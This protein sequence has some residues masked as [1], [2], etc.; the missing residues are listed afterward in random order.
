MQDLIFVSAQPDIPYFHWQTQVYCHNFIEKGIDPKNIHV[1]F[2]MIN[3]E[4]PTE[5]SLKLKNIGVNV[6]H[7]LD[8]RKDKFYIPSLRPM[9]LAKWLEENP[10]LSKKY[11]YHDAD[12]IFRQL[13]NFEKL[14][15]DDKIYLSDTISYIGYEYIKGCC[16]RYEA[17]YTDTKNLELFKIMSEVVGLD[18]DTIKENQENSGGAQYL[19]KNVGYK[20]WNKV[21]SDCTR[22]YYAIRDYDKKFSLP[23]GE[24]QMW[25]ADMWAVLWNLWLLNKETKVTKELSFSWAT[26]L[27]QNY[28]HHPILHMAGV[29]ESMKDTKFYKGEFIDVNP[30]EKL[31]ENENFFDYVDPKSTTIKY[32]EVIKSLVK[33]TK[34]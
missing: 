5:E 31:R 15:E 7:Y 30:I 13:P 21:F 4:T 34:N 33:K 8:T 10:K 32:V 24:I 18:M 14:L 22:L 1:L 27:V 25:T 2:V 16:Q 17:R 6:H 26:D 28:N 19:M 20:F 12:I 3:R 11:F 23:Y 9:I 29:Q